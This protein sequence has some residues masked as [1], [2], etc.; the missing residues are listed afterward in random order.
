MVARGAVA[1][2]QSVDEAAK[3]YNLNTVASMLMARK[4]HGK[5]DLEEPE[6]KSNQNSES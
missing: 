1:V 3:A 4:G 6:N 2:Q 5:I